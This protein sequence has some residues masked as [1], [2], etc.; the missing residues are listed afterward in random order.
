MKK[1]KYKIKEKIDNSEVA[2]LVRI[3]KDENFGN[4]SQ[5]KKMAQIL[6]TLIS[7][8]GR[9]VGTFFREL[10]KAMTNIGS[11][12][13]EDEGDVLEDMTEPEEVIEIEEVENSTSFI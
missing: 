1:Y 8:G 11:E 2:E 5:R 12:M 10:G 9:E 6:M 3:L 4:E 13:L 7:I